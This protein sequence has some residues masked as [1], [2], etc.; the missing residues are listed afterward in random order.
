MLLEFLRENSKKKPVVKDF[1]IPTG[2]RYGAGGSTNEHR[3][4]PVDFTADYHPLRLPRERVTVV[5]NPQ[6]F[7]EFLREALTGVRI[8]GIDAEWKPSFGEYQ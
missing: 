5:D 8:V 1:S 3:G 4:R 2:K 7:N 6:S